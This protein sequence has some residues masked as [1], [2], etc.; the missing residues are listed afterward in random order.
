[1]V[2]QTLTQRQ[3]SPNNS[4]AVVDPHLRIGGWWRDNG[5][6]FSGNIDEVKVYSYEATQAPGQC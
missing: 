2:S 4:V 3:S 6:R 5:Y 1:M